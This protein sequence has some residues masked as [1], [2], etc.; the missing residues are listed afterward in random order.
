MREKEILVEPSP[1]LL[2]AIKRIMTSFVYLFLKTGITFPQVAELLK[3]VYVDVADRHFRLDNKKQTQT[4]LSFLTGVHRKDVK[5][6][7][8]CKEDNLEPA[9]ISIG[10][11]IVSKWL[12][13]S[14][15]LDEMG[16]PL[17]LPL[18]SEKSPCFDELV[19]AVCKQDIRPRVILDEWLNLGVVLL[20]DENKVQLCTDAFIPEK[21]LDEKAFFLGQNISDHL[22]ATSDNLL[23]DSPKY[24]ERCVY[25]DD[26]SKESVD[27][28][29]QLVRE[30]GMQLLKKLNSRAASLKKNDV[31]GSGRKHR[32]NIGLYLY[33]QDKD[34]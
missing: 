3:E 31:V 28:L 25:Y 10:V 16:K 32:I 7:H 9:N 27:E 14:R 34:Q 12:S 4:R 15:Y 11:Q 8:D 5:R 17:L 29:Q 19:Q 24:F 2:I 6:L 33:H 30:H 20:N 23:N 22:S 1:A 13:D 18:K 26:L 21:G